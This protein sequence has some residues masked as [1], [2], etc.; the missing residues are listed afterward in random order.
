MLFIKASCD[1][2]PDYPVCFSRLGTDVF[3]EHLSS[4]GSL[5]VNKH[6]YSI[7]GMYRNL[8]HMTRLQEIFSDSDGPE[9]PRK[10]RK[11]EEIWFKGNSSGLIGAKPNLQDFP[12]DETIVKCWD[13]GLKEAQ[14]HLQSLGVKPRNVCSTDKESDWFYRP[15]TSLPT[16]DEESESE[17]EVREKVNFCEPDPDNDENSLSKQLQLIDE[18]QELGSHLRTVVE[19]LESE[20][21]GDFH[22]H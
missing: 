13:F 21:D 14:D 15:R 7:T 2:A 8:S 17:Q 22:P 18:N 19:H 1:Y 12:D 11:G 10:H 4:N 6:N 16:N 3:E 20:N 9:N 5:I